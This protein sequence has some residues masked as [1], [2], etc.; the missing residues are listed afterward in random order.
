MNIKMQCC[1]IIILFVLSIFYM[2]TKRIR[3]ATGDAFVRL[4]AAS[5]LNLVF[6]IMSLVAIEYRSQL[7]V[8]FVEMVCK[9]YLLMLVTVCALGF[10]YI[11][12]DVHVNTKK[13]HRVL[14]V[15]RYWIVLMCVGILLS[16]IYIY[17]AGGSTYTYGLSTTFTYIACVGIL[18]A[19]F[20]QM[21]V[22]RKELLARRRA[23]MYTWMV[24]WISSAFIQFLIPELL[25]VSFAG[26]VGVVV[27][28]LQIE[29][30]ELKLDSDTNL[31]NYN[32]LSQYMDY[33]YGENK[34][35]SVLALILSN[36]YEQKVSTM[37]NTSVM[38]RFTERY[39]RETDDKVFRI[40]DDE[41]YM[42]FDSLQEME[43]R[44]GEI[45]DEYANAENSEEK[46]TL[47]I[48]YIHLPDGR[49]VPDKGQLLKM[50]HFVRTIQ[51]DLER[52]QQ[53]F[54]GKE[55]AENILQQQKME[56]QLHEIIKDDRVEVFYQPIYSTKEKRFTSAEA[57]MRVRD[58]DGKIIPP[59]TYITVAEAN[60]IILQLGRM[61]F[62]KV[63][64]FLQKEQ[65]WQ[66]G[67]EYVEVNLSVMQCAYENLADEYIEIMKKYQIDPKRIN[68][69]IT[70]SAS[71]N[72]KNV[73]LKNMHKLI[74]YGVRFSLDD[75]GTGQSNLNYIVEM[76]VHLVK[77]DRDMI[78]AYFE[79]GKAKYVM[80]AAMQMIQGL[81]LEIVSEGIE[82]REQYLVMESLGI[83][84]IQGYYFSKPLAENAYLKFIR[85]DRR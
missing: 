9:L 62:E 52:E 53:V 44:A 38:R 67:L 8:L 49:V 42:V 48:S 15:F 47:R 61:I 22:N 70:E 60:G 29:N 59:Y 68:L 69:E 14:M 51:V 33:L 79:N 19:N 17:E 32:A 28:Y 71:S 40:A 80:N 20:V 2:R 12:S 1:G 55:Y 77:F 35:F 16:P 39:L 43:M 4:F 82:T 76:P 31:F 6:D 41:I 64:R 81:N 46:V 54:V 5:I 11:S 25:L 74:E 83:Q 24:I 66:Y 63:C 27:V 13:Y 18:V 37:D 3:M 75:F 34:S 58:V 7:P 50:L 65:P 45:A 57:L 21:K 73:L 56:Q 36:Q 72:A 78:N 23:A 84:H 30:P 10:Y 85:E 26:A